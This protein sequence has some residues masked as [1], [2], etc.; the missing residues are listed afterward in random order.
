MSRGQQ[1]GTNGITGQ[2]IIG[3]NRTTNNR[4]H[5]EQEIIGDNR[6]T[7]IITPQPVFHFL[8]ATPLSTQKHNSNTTHVNISTHL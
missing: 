6:T 7:N 4:R 2:E 1:I 5:T 3:N 8:Q